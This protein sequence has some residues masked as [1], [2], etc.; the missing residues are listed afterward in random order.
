MPRKAMTF[1]F[2]FSLLLF[3]PSSVYRT[4]D[5]FRKFNLQP[6]GIRAMA[7][8]GQ[9]SLEKIPRSSP[10]IPISLS[11]N[12]VSNIPEARETERS[13]FGSVS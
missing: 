13:G 3:T 4:F 7:G 2:A 6:N 5:E 11:G 10:G 8:D 1:Y 12:W 9:G